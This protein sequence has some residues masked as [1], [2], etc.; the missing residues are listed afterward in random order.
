MKIIFYSVITIMGMSLI[1]YSVF[2]RTDVPFLYSHY[3]LHLMFLCVLPLLIYTEVTIL[4]G[5]NTSVTGLTSKIILSILIIPLAGFILYYSGGFAFVDG[6][7]MKSVEKQM[8]LQGRTIDIEGDGLSILA[9]AISGRVVDV[10]TEKEYQFGP[11]DSSATDLMVLFK[12]NQ[13][14][15]PEAVPYHKS[16]KEV[17]TYQVRYLPF[18]KIIISAKLLNLESDI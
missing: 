5:T 10:E 8:Q 17:L 4:N 14:S 9:G 13:S 3:A 2:S 7:G 1:L 18:S 6:L 15:L 11:H 16:N 12:D